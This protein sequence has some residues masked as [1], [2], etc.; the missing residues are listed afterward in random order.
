MNLPLTGILRIVKPFGAIVPVVLF[1]LI[2]EL[3]SRNIGTRMP[4]LPPPSACVM[5][6]MTWAREDDLLKDLFSSGTLLV[7]G[8][9][10]G[11]VIGVVVGLLTGRVPRLAFGLVP[12]IRLFRP[13]P[14]VALLPLF[15]VLFGIGIRAKIFAIS[16]AVFFPVWLNTFTGAR[17]IPERLL[18]SASTLTK[19]RWRIFWRVV[20]PAA[21]PNIVTGIRQGISL[22]F[23]MVFVAELIGADA[24]IG[25]KISIYQLAFRMDAMIAALATLGAGGALTDW[26]FT[27]FMFWR[28]PYLRLVEQLP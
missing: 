15:I 22:G 5:A 24:G 19:S 17:Q 26:A 25:Y 1:L 7:F 10:C 14:P 11:S 2:W 6:F 23:V 27:A 20:L 28:Y 12:I 18:W 16:F 4:L 21:L 3:V 8:L 9:L 13:L